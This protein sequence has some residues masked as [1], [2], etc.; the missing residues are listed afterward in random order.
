M[1][2]I[3]ETVPVL[4]L[5]PLSHNPFLDGTV[6]YEN[7]DGVLVPKSVGGAVEPL[8][9]NPWLDAR[10]SNASTQSLIDSA[11]QT[12]RTGVAIDDV[13]LRGYRNVYGGLDT[14]KFGA[15]VDNMTDAQLDD[16]I[17][18]VTDDLSASRQNAQ[19]M[20]PRISASQAL[21]RGSQFAGALGYA[22]DAYNVADAVLDPTNNP[23]DEIGDVAGSMLGGALGT[24]LG[25]VGIL[26]GSL[27][28]GW[29]GRQLG[30]LLQGNGQQQPQ[31]EKV[32][33]A[34]EFHAWY[35][36]QK[37][38]TTSQE[39]VLPFSFANDPCVSAS[40]V[41]IVADWGF[42]SAQLTGSALEG[43]EDKLSVRNIR[44]VPPGE[45]PANSAD[46]VPYTP[47]D[48]NPIGGPAPSY[49]N[50]DNPTPYG[51]Q[52]DNPPLID[53]LGDFPTAPTGDFPTDAPLRP[54]NNPL[55]SPGGG[56]DFDSPPAPEDLPE[57]R[58]SPDP[59][60]EIDP[61]Q[62]E[63]KCCPETIAKL[64]EI[65]E[66]LTFTYQGV[67][68][69]TGCDDEGNIIEWHGEGLDGIYEAV[70]VLQEQ[71]QVIHENTKCPPDTTAAV[72]MTWDVRA[73]EH[74]QLII[75]WGPAEGGS[76][77]WAMHIPHPRANIGE[78]TV[79]KFPQ[80]KKG[81]VRGTWI[82]PDNTRIVI[83]GASEADCKKVF[84]YVSKLVDARYINKAEVMFTKG[85]SNFSVRDVKAVYA[86]AFSG[87]RSQTPL[88]TKRL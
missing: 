77:R 86:K 84:S 7:T 88:W 13:A 50:L 14:K 48:P 2:S 76:S 52:L 64:N 39:V 60:P 18:S 53:P 29:L 71:T 15:A 33:I 58:K 61:N 17:Q 16:F 30:N 25:P 79:F 73:M 78:N 57:P 41:C 66:R 37:W 68:D 72:P 45:D 9:A 24:P 87:H 82:L 31:G 62:P 12:T 83:N 47:G 81:P 5:K 6:V 49:P 32:T 46:T 85:R 80:Y 22:M 21:R 35:H 1:G 20:R 8:G 70:K 67:A 56:S 55:D 28:G 26:A 36:P 59:T 19:A 65:I 63:D 75:L 69:M 40:A 42:G 38:L 44:I 51:P 27:V 54:T 74:P 10:P 43:D 34:Y 4:D 11:R 3:S 23:L